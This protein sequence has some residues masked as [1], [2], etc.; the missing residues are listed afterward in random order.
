M[1]SFS[2]YQLLQFLAEH[3]Q[4]SVYGGLEY[5]LLPEMLAVKSWVIVLIKANVIARAC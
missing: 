3:T 4:K 1:P 2:V 5:E